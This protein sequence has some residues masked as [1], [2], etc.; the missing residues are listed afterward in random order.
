MGRNIISVKHFFSGV[1]IVKKMIIG[2]FCIIF[3]PVVTFGIYYYNQMSESM[4]ESVVMNRQ[5][6]MEQAYYNLKVDLDH[7]ESL[8]HLLQYNYFVIDYL[9]GFYETD[10]ESVYNYLRYISPLLLFSVSG[11]PNLASIKIYKNKDEVFP[12]PT[13]IVKINELNTGIKEKIDKLKPNEG[14]WIY[15]TEDHAGLTSLYYYHN[16]YDNS[17]IENLGVLEIKVSPSVFKPFFKALGADSH[18]EVYLL[19][20]QE[21]IVNLAFV[22]P[23]PNANKDISDLKKLSSHS[24]VFNRLRIDK[25]KM[26]V[27]TIGE[28][29]E[30]FG[31]IK[32]KEKVL[33]AAIF[34]LLLLLSFIYYIFASS[35]AKRLTRLA[36]H[37]RSVGENNLKVYPD[38]GNEDEIGFLTS[39]YNS[40]VRRIEELINNIHRAELLR[41][42]AAFKMLQ[43]QVKPHFLYNTLETIRMM[44]EAKNVPE[45]AEI[46]YSFGQLMRYSLTSSHDEIQLSKE[47]EMVGNYLKIHQIRLRNRLRF[48]MD[49]ISIADCVSCPR[50]ILQ[51]IVE[52]CVVHGLSKTRRP[53]EIRIGISQDDTF[54]VI[55]VEDNGGGMSH[56]KLSELRY[57]LSKPADATFQANEGGFG[58]ISVS[59]RIKIYYGSGSRLEMDSEEGKGTTIRLFLNKK[60]DDVDC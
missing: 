39:S 50:F 27:V 8:Y 24:T 1:S 6:I 33:A 45:V 44:A 48:E 53:I 28:V 16:L 36:R 2:Y 41:K 29:N 11:N 46:A 35:V 43:A 18:W 14:I 59:E 25:L 3:L 60:G 23:R 34:V 17:F 57:T 38:Q 5:Q 31:D 52:N 37:M 15:E 49:G 42:E 20:E 12:I 55:T 58:L 7:F 13:Q 10:S 40:M 21:D 19:T 26:S 47:L 4:M 51:P 9:N 56:S 22:P 54:I 30:M 32:S